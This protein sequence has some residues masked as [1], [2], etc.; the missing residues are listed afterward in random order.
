MFLFSS[1]KQKRMT[2]HILHFLTLGF[3]PKVFT[4]GQP[5]SIKIQREYQLS[6]KES[7]CRCRRHG[8]DLWV[9][10]ILWSR[11]WQPTRVF[12][13]GKFHGK[14]S[15]AG[16]SPWGHKESDMTWRAHMQKPFLCCSKSCSMGPWLSQRTWGSV[17]W[18]P[19]QGF[20]HIRR[21]E[22]RNQEVRE[23]K[24][25]YTRMS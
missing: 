2:V 8:F 17:Q 3:F 22:E 18:A 9:G 10:K 13:P 5:A 4:H 1:Y 25:G 21:G 19:M 12:L 14:R 7:A 11:K 23:Q 16:Y 15:L 20:C 24:P 6:G